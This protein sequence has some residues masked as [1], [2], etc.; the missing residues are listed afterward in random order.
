MTSISRNIDN[1]YPKAGYNAQWQVGLG[2]IL[3]LFRLDPA[4]LR[5][6]AQV[7]FAPVIVG[8]TTPMQDPQPPP[9]SGEPVMAR[10][11]AAAAI[12]HDDVTVVDA[13]DDRPVPAAGVGVIEVMDHRIAA[14]QSAKADRADSALAEVQFLGHVGV[15]ADTALESGEGVAG[16]LAASRRIAPPLREIALCRHYR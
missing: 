11:M 10:G 13:N 6:D 1:L 14:P 12:G 5:R 16:C 7:L 8:V 9:T 15:P 2:L 3:V 4:M